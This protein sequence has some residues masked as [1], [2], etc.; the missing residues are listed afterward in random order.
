MRRPPTLRDSG[1]FLFAWMG[2]DHFRQR[3]DELADPLFAK[4]FIIFSFG[5]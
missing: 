4:Q 2:D 1:R 3:I 5:H